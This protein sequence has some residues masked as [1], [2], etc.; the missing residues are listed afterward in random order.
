M[1]AALDCGARRTSGCQGATTWTSCPRAATDV[2]IG[3]MKVPTLSPGKRGY[4]VVTITT[5]SGPS[6]IGASRSRSRHGVTSDSSSTARE[7]FDCP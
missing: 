5:T 2:A 4:D 7:T 3:S 6:L 1:D